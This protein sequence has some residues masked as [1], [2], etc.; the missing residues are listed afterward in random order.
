MRYFGALPKSDR[1]RSGEGV[2][3]RNGCPKG[4]F[5]R[6]RFLSAPLRSAL[7]TSEDL[8]G[9]DRKRTLQKHS[10][11]HP[12]LRPT[13]SPLLWRTPT[14]MTPDSWKPWDVS[15]FG[16]AHDHSTRSF[17]VF[18]PMWLASRGHVV[19]AHSFGKLKSH[20]RNMRT[21]S[22]AL[23]RILA[24]RR[25]TNSATP[26]APYRSLPGPPGPESRKSLPKPSGPGV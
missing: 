8:K 2:G 5:W 19:Q 25:S 26:P 11:G 16:M 9:A 24:R 18:G 12:F 20:K 6:V 10:F 13:P 17:I 15:T 1:Q 22:E 7:K 21:K 4:C 23:S 3:R 14:K